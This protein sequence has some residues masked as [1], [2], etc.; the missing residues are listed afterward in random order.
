[1]SEVQEDLYTLQGAC[2][3]EVQ[4]NLYTLQGACV[5]EVQEVGE[6]QKGLMQ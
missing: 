1:M 2:V 6:E 5:S 3:S 4:E